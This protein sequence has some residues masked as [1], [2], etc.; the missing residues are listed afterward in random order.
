MSHIITIPVPCRY[1]CTPKNGTRQARSRFVVKHALRCK[2]TLWR[3][4]KKQT[5]YVHTYRIPTVR[6]V[7]DYQGIGAPKERLTCACPGNGVIAAV[8]TFLTTNA[9]LRHVLAYTVLY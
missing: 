2:L 1:T 3:E 7:V 8:R 4:E 9:M 5:I 6:T